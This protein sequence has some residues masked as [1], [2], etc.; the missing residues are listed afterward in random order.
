MPDLG[1]VLPWR[2]ALLLQIGNGSVQLLCFV[3][4]FKF[5]RSNGSQV[6]TFWSGYVIQFAA[7]THAP[8]KNDWESFCKIW[9][10][11]YSCYIVKRFWTIQHWLS[12]LMSGAKLVNFSA[13]PPANSMV[14]KQS[15]NKPPTIEWEWLNIFLCKKRKFADKKSYQ[16]PKIV[17]QEME[18]LR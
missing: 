15:P 14:T 4:R 7:G 8:R 12:G 6:S 16:E 3:E 17:Y 5:F 10:V 1:S 13:A 18:S 9:F 2:L 11:F